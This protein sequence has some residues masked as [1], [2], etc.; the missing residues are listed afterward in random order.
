MTQ[1]CLPP[2]DAL[3]SFKARHINNQQD[4]SPE[5]IF[6]YE[7]DPQKIF[8]QEVV[9][10]DIGSYSS[11]SCREEQYTV[12]CYFGDFCH[13]ELGKTLAKAFLL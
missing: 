7:V 8:P 1:T 3:S 9:T 13:T 4:D 12:H 11:H 6:I 2:L 10:Q 5:E